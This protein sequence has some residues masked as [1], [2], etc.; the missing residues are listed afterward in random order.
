MRNLVPFAGFKLTKKKKI[1]GILY[2]VKNISLEEATI[3]IH[4]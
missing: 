1:T 2:E 4:R 3:Y